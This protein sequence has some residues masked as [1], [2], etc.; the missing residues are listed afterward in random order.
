MKFF[1]EI[2]DLTNRD[3]DGFRIDMGIFEKFGEKQTKSLIKHYTGKNISPLLVVTCDSSIS[4]DWRG[5]AAFDHT[6]LWLVNRFGARGVEFSNIFL[7]ESSGQYP[8]GTRGYPKYH[9]T[10]GFLNSSNNFSIYP[11]TQD[12]GIKT[13]LFLIDAPLQNPDRL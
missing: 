4:L 1:E 8:Q 9:F 5:V 13:A 3:K 12:A 11:L 2:K 7:Y 10:F 6:S